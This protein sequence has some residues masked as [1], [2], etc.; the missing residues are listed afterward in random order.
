R[1][2]GP[3]VELALARLSHHVAEV[4]PFHLARPD[5]GILEGIDGRRGEELRARPLVPAELGDPHADHGDLAHMFIVADVADAGKAPVAW[6]RARESG[7]ALDPVRDSGGPGSVL[8]PA[9]APPPAVGWSGA[10]PESPAAARPTPPPSR[11][12]SLRAPI[13]GHPTVGPVGLCIVG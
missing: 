10:E 4:D 6:T 5:P 3:H 1:D 8:P 2:L 13:A 12:A 9:P 11:L 7:D